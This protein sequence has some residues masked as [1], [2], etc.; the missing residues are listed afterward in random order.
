MQEITVFMEDM[1]Q[2]AELLSGFATLEEEMQGIVRE[3][4]W[5]KLEETILRI[6]KKSEMLD[7]AEEKRIQSFD[8]LKAA[9]GV[10]ADV[11]FFGILPMVGEDIRLPLSEAYR[12]LKVAVYSVKG[13]TL[14]LSYYFRSIS[15]TL[16][17]VLA[18]IFPHRKGTMY[19]H[20][21]KVSKMSDASMI[22]DKRL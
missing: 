3:K 11:S 8:E 22:L 7:K 16:K 18:E 9:L 20:N 15:E 19:S 4:Q 1:I 17:G 12:K 21:G 6:R 2:E 14:R 13:A 5:D 10:P